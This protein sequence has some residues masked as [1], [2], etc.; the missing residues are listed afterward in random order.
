VASFVFP[1]R[2]HGL[3]YQKPLVYTFF[4]LS[5][6]AKRVGIPLDEIRVPRFLLLAIASTPRRS[7][8]L[9]TW[10]C[11]PIFSLLSVLL[12]RPRGC[13]FRAQRW[14]SSIITHPTSTVIHPF[15][16]AR[17]F[18]SYPFRLSVSPSS[19]GALFNPDAVA[20]ARLIILLKESE[21]FRSTRLSLVILST[22]RLQAPFFPS[23][24]I[25]HSFHLEMRFPFR[26]PGLP[27]SKP[28]FLR[29]RSVDSP[30]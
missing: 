30:R 16:A 22:R 3:R 7:S 25:K 21:S 9:V 8:H 24:R 5:S 19:V 14:Q 29:Q 10:V 26:P 20:P 27:L 17:S 13:Y 1:L 18:F 23:P 11:K 15:P 28:E 2:S 4:N 12:K 6:L